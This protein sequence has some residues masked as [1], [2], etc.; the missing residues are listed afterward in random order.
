MGSLVSRKVQMSSSAGSRIRLLGPPYSLGWNQSLGT[1]V[2]WGT[3]DDLKEGVANSSIKRL[4]LW[5]KI[6]GL[7]SAAN[8][9]ALMQSSA[10]STNQKIRA[11][12]PGRPPG[13]GT[14]RN[15]R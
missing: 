2:I 11:R 6:P 12:W 10:L 1:Y 3:C 5:R 14:R 4:V 9:E 7:K 15:V 8:R 13:N